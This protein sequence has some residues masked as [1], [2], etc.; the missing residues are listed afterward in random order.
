MPRNASSRRASATRKI[1]LIPDIHAPRHDRKAWKLAMK[2]LTAWSPDVVIQLGDLIDLASV[3][4]YAKDPRRTMSLQQEIEVARDVV[5]DIAGIGA[6][7]TVVTLGN[8]SVR[9]E[10]YL[11]KNAPDFLPYFEISKVLGMQRPGWTVVPY[12]QTYTIGE[13]RV[14]HDVGRAG[15]QAA[16]QSVLD[17]GDNIVFGH[18]HRM[19]V[20][21]QGTQAGKRHVGA[22][23]GWLG[24]SNHIDYRHQD[25]VRR[26][27]QLGFG[28][29][30]MLPTGEFWLQAIPIVKNTCVIDG[31]VY[32]VR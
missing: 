32:S 29:A 18:T 25:M 3:S 10:S 21:Y 15:V 4:T 13:L 5:D 19:Q 31:Q 8:H 14:T 20:H 23:L 28:V 7:L 9:A 24:D 17:V 30:H 22:T 11:I 26:D 27:W 1:A 16:R 6:P 12:K 2:A